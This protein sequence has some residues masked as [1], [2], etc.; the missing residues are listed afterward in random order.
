MSSA[1]GYAP[2]LPVKITLLITA[3]LLVAGSSALARPPQHNH[4]FDPRGYP[5]RLVPLPGG[6]PIWVN[7]GPC[8][9]YPDG[10]AC[11]ASRTHVIYLDHAGG[12]WRRYL[13]AH[14]LGHVFDLRHLSSAERVAFMH[15]IGSNLPWWSQSRRDHHR[16]SGEEM[17]ADAYAFC[18]LHEGPAYWQFCPLISSFK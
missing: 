8:P 9:D 18:L 14:E 13:L 3:L 1:I 5:R 4:R 11:L 2:G 17:F 15:A 7:E 12:H 10:G 6:P 16:D